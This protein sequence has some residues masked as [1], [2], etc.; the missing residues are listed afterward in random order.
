MYDSFSLGELLQHVGL[1]NP[2]CY[3]PTES[4]IPNWNSFHLDSEADGST[5][6]PGS[7]FMEAVKL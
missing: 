6:K 1:S 2:Q 5:Y 7:L 3:G 4:Q